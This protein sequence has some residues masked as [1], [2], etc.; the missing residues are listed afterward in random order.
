MI[1]ENEVIALPPTAERVGRELSRWFGNSDFA[2]RPK[3]ALT[4]RET[5]RRVD[6]AR[7]DALPVDARGLS[8]RRSGWDSAGSHWRSRSRSISC[9]CLRL[10]VSIIAISLTAPSKPRASANSSSDCSAPPQCSAGRS[11]GRHTIAIITCIRTSPR[12][13]TRPVQHGFFWSHMGWFMSHKHFAADLI[14]G[15]G[16]AQVSGAAVPGSL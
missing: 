15:E 3:E 16:S 13:C 12:T 14:A 4:P 1:P 2:T 9:A 5:S 7:V 8:R 11:G 6:W 10:P